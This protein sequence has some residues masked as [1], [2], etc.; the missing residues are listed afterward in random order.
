MQLFLSEAVQSPSNVL[1]FLIEIADFFADTEWG[2]YNK[3]QERGKLGRLI[4]QHL[5]PSYMW[6]LWMSSVYSLCVWETMFS[7]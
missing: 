5:G 7:F 1:Y 6:M 4:K 3:F 2:E